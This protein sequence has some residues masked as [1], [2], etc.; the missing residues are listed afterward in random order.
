MYWYLDFQ[1]AGITGI[2]NSALIEQ[3]WS[4]MA[5]TDTKD[6][7]SETNEVILEMEISAEHSFLANIDFT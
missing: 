4:L 6:S 1:I 3:Y 7:Q 5:D 2:T